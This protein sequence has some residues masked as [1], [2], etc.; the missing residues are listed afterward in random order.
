[1]SKKKRV[2]IRDVAA[3]AGVSP[4]AVSFA[5]NAPEQL[6]QATYERILRVAA[7]LQYQPHP[8]ARTLATGRTGILGLVLPADLHWTLS[9]PFFRLF[10]GEFGALCDKHRLHL[11]L[12][13]ARS[14]TNAN[15]LNSVAADGFLIIGIN[16]SHALSRAAEQAMRPVVL[17]DSERSI[18]APQI[19][20]DD[21]QGAYLAAQHLIERGHTN[22]AVSAMRL[23]PSK[24]KSVPYITRIEGYKQAVADAGLPPETLQIVYT[25]ENHAADAQRGVDSFQAI[26]S[27]PQRP[28]AVLCVSDTRGLDIMQA[29]MAAGVSIPN[30]LAII[31]FD[32]IPEAATAPVPLTTIRQNVIQR[33]RRAFHL[34]NR[35]IEEHPQSDVYQQAQIDPVELVVR[36]SS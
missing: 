29:A 28:T 36:A 7:R 17:L 20:L 33:C 14:D 4:T 19:A 5:F 1:M 22:I 15:L 9:D 8:V 35:L 18:A 16:Q 32:D 2:T 24:L 23:T 26:W 3:E 31:G 11:L 25:E 34:L 6:G 13:S 21:F 12:V 10:I 27:L 30:E